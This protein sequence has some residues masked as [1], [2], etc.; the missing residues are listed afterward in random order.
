MSAINSEE[1][2]AA[3]SIAALV[4][5]R[6]Y[7]LFLIMPVFSI[8]AEKL[9]FSTP[10]LIGLAVGMYG[11]T[12]A[13]L[14]VPMGLL[15]DFW[16]RKKVMAIGLLMFFVGSVVAALAND[17][18]WV[19]LGRCVQGMG[20]IASTGMAYIA[21]VSR[22]EQRA[23]MMGIVG[24][25]IGFAFMLSFMTG[26]LLAQWIGIKGL[27]WLTAVLALIALAL[28]FV[29]V[30]EPR[31]KVK[32]GFSTAELIAAIKQKDLLLLDVFVF[33]LHASMSA[34]FVVLPLLMLHQ[35]NFESH[36][37]WK[38]YVP[39]LILSLFIMIPLIILQEKKKQHVKF[40][41]LAMLG[42]SLSV[43]L[44]GWGVKSLWMLALMMTVYFGLF[45]FLEAAMPS[46]LSKR[47]DD[48]YRGAA[49]GVYSSSQFFG[50]FIGGVLAGYVMQWK[51]EYVFYA[52][53]V[54]LFSFTALG[55]K[56]FKNN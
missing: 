2:K 48:Q 25:S 13:L 40:L 31:K 43:L 8:Y 46:L 50:A 39:V 9:P 38:L 55:I 33:L 4:S 22:P 35:L 24:A 1:K 56:A 42:L 26:P 36:A 14:Q 10:V 6:V 12:Q 23:K 18:Y 16:G 27:F 44:L 5:L 30:K 34:I 7:G 45:N 15:S 11:L 53:F 52:I 3:L 21:D 20:A 28:L 17:I 19:I 47:A 29:A 41:L 51:A 37:H 32:K 49:M 54:L